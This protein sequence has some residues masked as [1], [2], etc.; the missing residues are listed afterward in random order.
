MQKTVHLKEIQADNERATLIPITK[1][2]VL[3]REKNNIADS[4]FSYQVNIKLDHTSEYLQKLST[5]NDT[6]INGN[7]EDRINKGHQ[8]AL[9]AHKSSF[10]GNIAGT[11]DSH[12][13]QANN[14]NNSFIFI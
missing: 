6:E 2:I 8:K 14:S 10:E 13:I 12:A 1:K 9:I 7:L 5:Q 11:Q 3:K 4:V